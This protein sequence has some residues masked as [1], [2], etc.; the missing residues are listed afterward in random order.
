MVPVNGTGGTSRGK[1]WD[2]DSC[3]HTASNNG[4]LLAL[5][6]LVE[7]RQ[8]N[9]SLQEKRVDFICCITSCILTWTG[10]QQSLPFP[11][12]THSVSERICQP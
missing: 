11:D 8:L 5:C 12:G 1:W 4:L 3:A 10:V 7:G 6:F 9:G 2:L